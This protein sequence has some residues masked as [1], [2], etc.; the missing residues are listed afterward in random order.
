MTR[1]TIAAGD[2]TVER[3]YSE[4]DNLKKTLSAKSI[5]YCTT[6]DE[7]NNKIDDTDT[8]VFYS[9]FPLPYKDI[10]NLAK[11]S[12]SVNNVI[13]LEYEG[14]DKLWLYD[15]ITVANCIMPDEEV[16]AI[17]RALVVPKTVNFIGQWVVAILL[18]F[19]MSGAI[20]YTQHQIALASRNVES[21]QQEDV[22]A[23]S[24]N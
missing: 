16:A 14:Q 22:P 18:I 23:K 3:L 8:L 21:T 24:L 7:L 17:N 6:L 19:F 5:E 1:V 10:C 9:D 2:S 4:E 20:A 13:G 11:E 12:K 15:G